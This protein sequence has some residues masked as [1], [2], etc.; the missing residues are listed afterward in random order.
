MSAYK[1]INDENFR[2]YILKQKADVFQAMKS[3]FRKEENE[4][5]A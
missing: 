5:Y 3:F 4:M 2:Y 1:N